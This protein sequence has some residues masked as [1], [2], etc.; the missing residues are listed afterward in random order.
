MISIKHEATSTF[1]KSLHE[2]RDGAKPVNIVSTSDDASLILETRDEA[3]LLK[4]GGVVPP[5][6]MRDDVALA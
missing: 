3:C 4:L 5:F 2:T 1:E 6:A